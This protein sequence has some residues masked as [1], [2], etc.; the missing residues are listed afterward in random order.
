MTALIDKLSILV[1]DTYAIYLKTQNYHWHVQGPQFKSLHELFDTQ[2][3]ELA[4]AVDLLAERLRIKGA[5]AP[6]T[7]KALEKLKTLNDGDSSNT[8]NQM[9]VELA[10][11]HSTL[12][13]DLQNAIALAE[14]IKDEGT[15][16]LLADRIEA[17]EKARWMLTASCEIAK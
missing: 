15:E 5:F 4:D 9:V 8:A 7:F 13:Q 1:A 11:D 3:H 6:A 16:N 14:K 10:K 2:Y 12:I 17:H